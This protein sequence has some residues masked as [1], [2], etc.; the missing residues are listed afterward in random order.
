MRFNQFAPEA[1]FLFNNLK[2]AQGYQDSFR[3]LLGQFLVTQ[4]IFFDL[5]CDNNVKEGDYYFLI[6]L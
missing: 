5:K 2:I 4:N 1:E 3:P 6:K